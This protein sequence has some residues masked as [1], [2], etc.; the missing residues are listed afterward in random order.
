MNGG[1]SPEKLALRSLGR[2]TAPAAPAA[3]VVCAAFSQR[4]G[5]QIR[6]TEPLVH[7]L[8]GV[9]RHRTG[10]PVHRCGGEP[11]AAAARLPPQRGRRPFHGA[12]GGDVRAAGYRSRRHRLLLL[13][14]VSHAGHRQLVQCADRFRHGRRP[15]AEPGHAEHEQA[16]AAALHGTDAGEHRRQLP[17]CPDP[18]FERPSHPFG[19]DGSGPGHAPGGDTG[20]QP[21]K[22]GSAGSQYA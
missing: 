20:L 14:A 4:C 13:P 2:C 18:D 5:T 3:P 7:P 17:D 19:S 12:Y 10:D 22:P 9:H 16:P 21:R 15:G 1:C 11:G 8:A 6:R